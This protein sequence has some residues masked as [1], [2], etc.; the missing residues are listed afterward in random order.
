MFDAPLS[1]FRLVSTEA[2]FLGKIAVTGIAI[3]NGMSLILIG[4][5]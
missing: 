2:A 1:G 4:S 3:G 5:R